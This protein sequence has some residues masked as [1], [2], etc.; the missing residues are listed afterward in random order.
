MASQLGQSEVICHLFKLL[1]R[2]V[3]EDE[4]MDAIAQGVVGLSANETLVALDDTTSAGIEGFTAGHNPSARG[5]GV[6]KRWGTRRLK[7]E[8]YSAE[9]PTK[10][11]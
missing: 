11:G 3:E 4:E 2:F 9:I 7:D 5:S 1:D 8:S 10:Q 6:P